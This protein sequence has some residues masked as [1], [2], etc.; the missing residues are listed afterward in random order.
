MTRFYGLNHSDSKNLD[1]LY[2]KYKE[3]IQ[4][5]VIP[6]F[7]ICVGYDGRPIL[8]HI[9]DSENRYDVKARFR[10]RL[11]HWFEVRETIEKLGMGAPCEQL[12][13]FVLYLLGCNWSRCTGFPRITKPDAGIDFL[14]VK[15]FEIGFEGIS[16]FI[17]TLDNDR[18]SGKLT[19]HRVII[20][21]VG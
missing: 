7:L 12:S 4:R 18:Y 13:A 14:G 8:Y 2:Y 21:F 1:R 15:E 11:V 19:K 17:R 10:G 20:R 6:P 9:T 16:S 3:D 5:C